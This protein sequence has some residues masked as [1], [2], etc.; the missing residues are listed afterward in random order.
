MAGTV[1]LIQRCYLGVEMRANVLH[2]DPALP[3]DLRRV[4]LCLHYRGQTLCVEANHARL[5]ITSGSF[6]SAPITIAYRG[7]FRELAPGDAC[8]FRLLKPEERDRDENRS[9][10]AQAPRREKPS[11]P[12]KPA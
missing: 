1:D 6:T 11:P 3:S 7:H 10:R 5:R 4:K 2:F 12:V 8:E 9:R